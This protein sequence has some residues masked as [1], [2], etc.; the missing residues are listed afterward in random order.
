MWGSGPWTPYVARGSRAGPPPDL[1]GLWEKGP[2][3][4]C[5]PWLAGKAPPWEPPVCFLNPKVLAGKVPGD[6][7]PHPAPGSRCSAW[8]S[9]RGGRP[10]SPPPRSPL[11]PCC[12]HCREFSDWGLREWTPDTEAWSH[13]GPCPLG[14]RASPPCLPPP[15]QVRVLRGGRTRWV[16]GVQDVASQP[17]PREEARAS[18]LWPLPSTLGIFEGSEGTRGGAPGGL[19]ARYPRAHP[20]AGT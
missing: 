2:S 11:S 9:A 19:V 18:C 14:A 4:L 17:A 13:K 16:C 3:T 5:P 10:C 8:S 12:S 6:G 20:A 1:A 7:P 15:R